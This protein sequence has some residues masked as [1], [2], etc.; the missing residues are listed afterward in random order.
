[1][2]VVRDRYFSKISERYCVYLIDQVLLS[3]K[4]L[5]GTYKEVIFLSLEGRLDLN[6]EMSAMN[7]SKRRRWVSHPCTLVCCLCFLLGQNIPPKIHLSTSDFNLEWHDIQ[8][9][10]KGRLTVIVFSGPTSAD[11]TKGRGNLYDENFRFFLRHGLPCSYP[12]QNKFAKQNQHVSVLTLS[13]N[14]KFVFVLTKDTKS[15]YGDYIRA[16]NQSA[17]GLNDLHIVVRED[18][19]YDLESGRLVYREH[20]HL[21]ATSDYVV[22]LNCGLLGPLVHKAENITNSVGN[23]FWATT[24]T[25]RLTDSVKLSGL[26]LNCGGKLDVHHAHVQSML[27]ATGRIGL[28]VILGSDAIYDC[29]NQL[30][31]PSG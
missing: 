16:L 3:S 28:E 17:C 23:P 19:C 22:F 8:Q 15:R 30:S 12:Y 26:S 6:W 1:M 4:N 25:D 31:Q 20:P 7:V 11:T 2:G 10:S 27:W 14:F 9:K 21:Y 29:G 24:F 13:S 18:K 5:V